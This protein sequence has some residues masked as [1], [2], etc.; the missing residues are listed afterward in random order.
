MASME[1]PQVKVNVPADRSYRKMI[2]QTKMVYDQLLAKRCEQLMA[3]MYEQK[4]EF[5]Q[6]VSAKSSVKVDNVQPM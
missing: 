5:D 3:E 4:R 2:E 1:A 6:Q